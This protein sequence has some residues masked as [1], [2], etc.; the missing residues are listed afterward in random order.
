MGVNGEPGAAG[1]EALEAQAAH[2]SSSSIICNLE[3]SSS[4]SQ[5]GMVNQSQVMRTGVGWVGYAADLLAV[6]G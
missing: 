4:G 6:L 1:P 5:C 2:R 3:N